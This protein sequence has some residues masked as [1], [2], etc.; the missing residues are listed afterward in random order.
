MVKAT[1]VVL[2]I[3]A[4]IFALPTA[5]GA[6]AYEVTRFDGTAASSPAVAGTK[7]SNVESAAVRGTDGNVYLETFNPSTN[8][9]NGWDAL[10]APPPGVVGDPALVS[11]GPGRLDLFVRGGDNKLWQ[12]WRPSA[13]SF[14]SPWI[15]PVGPDGTLASSPAVSSRGP[16]RLDVFVLGND[17]IVY[18]RLYDGAWNLGWLNQ[19][20]PP[21]AVGLVGDLSSASGDG[22]QVFVAGRGTDDKLWL[23]KWDGASW[24]A[25]VKPVGD[26]GTL[27]SKPA[28][29]SDF[30]D[31]VVVFVR[32]T[33]QNL[34]SRDLSASMW[35]RESITGVNPIK[36]GP[37][38]IVVG[39]DTID[40]FVHG[41]DDKV[42]RLRYRTVVTIQ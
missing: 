6:Q 31:S 13:D 12:R 23:R 37:G 4:A 36:D 3:A 32:G 17:G 30:K 15:Q 25:W 11:W 7:G 16:G 41:I 40:A 39:S 5:A 34:W 18:Q 27:A 29:V 14:W 38:A 10:G 1:A 35:Q 26:D 33:D 22:V 20:E 21:G 19:G 42:Y 9:W 8:A 2:S 24:S 28:I